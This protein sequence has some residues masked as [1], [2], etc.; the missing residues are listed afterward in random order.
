MEALPR[1]AKESIDSNFKLVELL[2]KMAQEKQ[3]TTAQLALAWVLTKDKNIVPIFG[4]K[5]PLR[6][7]ENLKALAVQLTQEDMQY[8]DQISKE[9]APKQSRYTEEAM[10]TYHLSE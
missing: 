8:L 4:T 1:F 9:Y 2:E 3:C 7:D 5:N 10:K 6:L